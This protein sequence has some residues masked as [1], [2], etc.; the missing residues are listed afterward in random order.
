[1]RRP[2]FLLLA[3]LLILPLSSARRT[4]SSV[5]KEKQENAR[6]IENTRRQLDANAAQTSRELKNLQSIEGKMRVKRN[7]ANSLRTSANNVKMNS[8]V[9]AD[10]I[11]YNTRHLE[12][13]RE[14]YGKALRT[15]RNRRHYSSPAAYV[16]SAGSFNEARSRIRYLEELS[17]WQA[18]KA[19]SLK[20]AT[21]RLKVQQGRLDSLH[22]VLATN[23]DSLAA[24][25][26]TLRIQR[27]QADAVVGSLKRQRRNLGKVLKEQERLARKL[28]DELNRIIEEESRR[29]EKKPEQKHPEN[30]TRLTGSFASNK[31]KLPSPVDRAATVVSTF[32]RHTH[33][34]LEKVQT[35]NNGM[36]FETTKGAQACAV[37]PG[38]VSMV[39]VMEG[40]DNVVL[41]RHGEYLTVYAGIDGL[42]VRKGQKVEAGQSLGSIYSDPTDNDRTRLHFEVRHEKEKLNP[43][44]WLR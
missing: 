25:E 30:D 24:V 3:I 11:K 19:R 37:F 34:E 36:D 8:D 40:F 14:S 21:S 7:E 31:G 4:S 5:R 39:I 33:E 13:L 1:M 26:Q 32:G 12:A 41:L 17:Q 20:A 42:K 28:D 15:I 29:N 18:E 44:D 23:L 9:L 22:N 10:S 16:L 2:L 35:Q 43:A 27:N 6:K 38:V